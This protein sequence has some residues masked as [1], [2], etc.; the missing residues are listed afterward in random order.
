MHTLIPFNAVQEI[1]RVDEVLER[2]FGQ[3]TTQPTANSIPI[4]LLEIDGKFVIRA[5][6]PGVSPDSLNITVENN[7]LNIKG[8]SNSP[9]VEGVKVYRSEIIDGSFSRSIRLP[10]N[11]NLESVDANFKNGNVTITI[12][13]IVEETLKITIKTSE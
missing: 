4:D 10:G 9:A 7:I 13:R 3:N 2:L 11:L 6:V 1:R 8:E 5:S 12:P